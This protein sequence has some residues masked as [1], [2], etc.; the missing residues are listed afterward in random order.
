VGKIE[1]GQGVLRIRRG[2]PVSIILLTSLLI[3]ILMLLVSEGQTG[4]V[5]KPANKAALFKCRETMA[6]QVLSQS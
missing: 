5:C 2:F 1:F 3:A 4:V 6:G